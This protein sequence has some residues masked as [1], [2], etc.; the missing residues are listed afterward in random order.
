MIAR[1]EWDRT[2]ADCQTYLYDD[3]PG[4]RRYGLPLLRAGELVLQDQPPVT[5]CAQCPKIAEGVR[6]RAAQE[7]RLVGPADA[8]EPT[9]MHRAV[10]EHFLECEAIRRFPNDPWVR[11]HARI[12]RPIWEQARAAAAGPLLAWLKAAIGRGE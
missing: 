3:S 2:C 6:V 12:I 10:V 4:S 8:D 9:P 11:R 5:P 1:P 7:G